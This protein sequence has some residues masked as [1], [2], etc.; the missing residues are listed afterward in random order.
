[1]PALTGE[2]GLCVGESLRLKWCLLAY[3]GYLVIRA[4][5]IVEIISH[6]PGTT[7]SGKV[8]G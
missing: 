5:E 2:A 3:L 8:T 7:N 4:E 1:M 6:H